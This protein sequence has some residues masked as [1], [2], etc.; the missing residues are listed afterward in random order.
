[1]NLQAANETENHHAGIVLDLLDKQRHSP[2]NSSC[3][4]VLIPTREESGRKVRAHRSLV[5]LNPTIFDILQPSQN[6]IGWDAKLDVTYDTLEALIKYMYTGV[7][8]FRQDT[9]I[10][11][12]QAAAQYK[13]ERLC[14]KAREF[15][16]K[17]TVQF[18]KSQNNHQ[19]ANPVHAV[20]EREAAAKIQTAA[21]EYNIDPNRYPWLTPGCLYLL[22][23]SPITSVMDF[24]PTCVMCSVPVG[25]QTSFFQ[26]QM[27]GHEM[28]CQRDILLA[29][30]VNTPGNWQRIRAL[31]YQAVR[32]EGTIHVNFQLCKEIL[33]RKPCSYGDN[34]TF[35]QSS[36]ELEIWNA[37][38]RG[39]FMRAWVMGHMTGH[40]AHPYLKGIITRYGGQFT[41]SNVSNDPAKP[42]RQLFHHSET[43]IRD[44]RNC[45]TEICWHEH[46]DPGSCKIGETCHF[47]HSDLE[48]EIWL[49]LRSTS[50][51]AQ[52]LVS[53]SENGTLS[54][55]RKNPD[56][57]NEAN[58]VSVQPIQEFIK[59]LFLQCGKCMASLGPGAPVCRDTSQG[60][61]QQKVIAIRDYEENP[62]MVR[63]LFGV[64]K[65]QNLPKKF[66]MC[67]NMR[68]RKECH[69]QNA[70]LFCHSSA[71]ICVWK[72]QKERELRDQERL[73]RAILEECETAPATKKYFFAT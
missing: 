31:P 50:L 8:D 70:C 43:R 61:G 51:S 47:A 1:M 27:P 57:N 6:D 16:N 63:N 23:K 21:A 24:L 28:V 12:I 37:E 25:D 62:Y 19:T 58:D 17:I 10:N 20:V 42:K 56:I 3:D 30:R 45:K 18:S 32:Q 48:L 41:F 65:N 15:L 33:D 2:E 46:R 69:Y 11:I 44:P 68:E 60:H 72:F 36:E 59:E 9:V 54:S 35:A 26:Q 52:Q 55:K 29:R 49:L 5:S 4:V 13:M 53:F 14:M 38:K 71:E 39:E 22:A 7:T 34:C 67:Q 66:L 73:Y 40:D 64:F